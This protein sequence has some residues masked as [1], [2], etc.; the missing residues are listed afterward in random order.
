LKEENWD[1]LIL[2]SHTDIPN[3]EINRRIEILFK[4]IIDADSPEGTKLYELLS[5]LQKFG[6][7]IQITNYSFLIGFIEEHIDIETL[8]YLFDFID[9]YDVNDSFLLSEV[10]N[11]TVQLL[12]LMVSDDDL[13][14]DYTSH[15]IENFY[16]DGYVDFDIDLKDLELEIFERLEVT[17]KTFNSSTVQKIDFKIADVMSEINLDYLASTFIDNYE[18]F[19]DDGTQEGYDAHMY[20]DDIDAIFER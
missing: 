2:L 17:L 1:Y 9:E 4:A 10:K 13:E 3:I 20:H 7:S 5:L 16:E 19:Y 6:S 8:K 15:L 11:R 18:P 12:E 14:I